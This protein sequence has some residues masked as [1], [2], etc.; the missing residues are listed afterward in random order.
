MR[1]AGVLSFGD[2]DCRGRDNFVRTSAAADWLTARLGAP[3]ARLDCGSI[4]MEGLCHGRR[5]VWCR[6]GAITAEDCGARCGWDGAAGG[7]RCD[8]EEPDA[9]GATDQLGTC[10]GE[11][12]VWC[13]RGRARRGG[14]AG[15]GLSC[16]RSP[17]TGAVAC[18]V[19]GP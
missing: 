16:G 18:V 14:C 13:D 2:R 11:T 5:A 10:E 4:G 1:V 3:A 15:C 6:E 12:M 9:C 17:S 19:P 8:P 7:Y